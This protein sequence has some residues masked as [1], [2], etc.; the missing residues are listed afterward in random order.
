MHY[1]FSLQ[2]IYATCPTVVED[3]GTHTMPLL[4]L[5]VKTATPPCHPS[6]HRQREVSALGRVAS[7]RPRQAMLHKT[8][9]HC[10]I[11]GLAWR[12]GI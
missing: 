12:A 4:K 1:Q 11:K 6:P 10:S 3:I 2:M 5:T 7:Q 9:C 8:P